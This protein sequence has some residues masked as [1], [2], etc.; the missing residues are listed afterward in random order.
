MF[1]STCE[2]FPILPC[3]KRNGTLDVDSLNGKNIR[4]GIE[5]GLSFDT[6]YIEG[7]TPTHGAAKKVT[8]R[9]SLAPKE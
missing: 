6:C 8:S 9:R 7:Y 1:C 4:A 3:I 2:D 5:E